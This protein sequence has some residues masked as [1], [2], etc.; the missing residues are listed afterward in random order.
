M[1][2]PTTLAFP[3]IMDQTRNIHEAGQ[4]RVQCPDS[5]LASLFPLEENTPW[6]LSISPS[7]TTTL[8]SRGR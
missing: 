1:T 4:L 6:W 3:K 8:R 2:T 7:A 5:L